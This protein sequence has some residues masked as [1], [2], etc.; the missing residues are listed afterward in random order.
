MKLCKYSYAREYTV[1]PRLTQLIEI[2]AVSI[3]EVVALTESQFSRAKNPSSTGRFQY[4]WTIGKFKAN[5]FSQ[6]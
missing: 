4:F 1:Q 5:C 3:T 6:K 2:L